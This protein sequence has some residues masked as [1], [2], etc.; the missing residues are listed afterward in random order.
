MRVSLPIVVAAL[1]LLGSRAFADPPGAAE[2]AADEKILTEAHVA[3]DGPS[4]VHYFRKRSL[5]EEDLARLEQT[6][7]RLGA[8]LYADRERA[9]RDLIEAGRPAVAYLKKAVDDPDLEIA[10]RVQRCL[11]EIG[12]SRDAPVVLAAARLLAVRKPEGAAA[13]ILGYLP[14]AE[15]LAEEELLTALGAV[16]SPNG[17]PDPALLRAL[18]DRLPER[19]GAAALVLGSA[20]D[21]KS[22]RPLLADATPRVRLRAAQGLLV[23]KKKEGV[24]AL[25]ALLAEGPL[26]EAW[27]AEELLFRLAGDKAPTVSVGA[28]EAADRKRSRDTWTTWWRDHGDKVDLAQL[29]LAD[30]PAG[31]TLIAAYDGYNQGKGKV[32]EVSADG[33]TRWQID[34]VRGPVDAQVLPG[35][36]VLIAEYNAAKFT[37]RTFDGKIVWERTANGSP[38]NCRR[39]PNG[40]TFLATTSEIRE[41]TADGKDVYVIGGKQ[42]YSAYKM[43]TGHIAYLSVDGSV[44]EVDTAGK[45]V[46]KFSAGPAP[47]GLLKFAVLPAGR[48]LVPQQTAGK[49]KEFDAAGKVVWEGNIPNSRVVTRLPNG[50]TLVCGH[51]GDHRIAEVDRTGRIVWEKKLE[52]H[53]HFA[54]R[55]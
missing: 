39:L 11:T 33:R 12:N 50:N 26:A 38:V 9:S 13:A 27:Q 15:E 53:A 7:R 18:T 1:L 34:D 16:G 25:L 5:T 47:I 43:R 20:G 28:G 31:L 36:R 23:G 52:G 24:P 10:H 29:A 14:F 48:F 30:R 46:R 42:V 2:I 41:I 44:V 40:N 32:F 6:V 35:N 45:E 51:N 49:V 19:R 54:S 3:T 17:T 8:P 4:L 21:L 22:V 37:E 55:R